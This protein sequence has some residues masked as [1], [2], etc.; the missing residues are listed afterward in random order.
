[1]KMIFW[2]HALHVGSQQFNNI[3]T[4]SVISNNHAIAPVLGTFDAPISFYC[5]VYHHLILQGKDYCKKDR[6]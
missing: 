1:M 3:R 5:C 4:A 2:Q 6:A